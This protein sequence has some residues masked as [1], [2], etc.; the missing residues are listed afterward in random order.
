MVVEIDVLGDR[1][2]RGM[3]IRPGRLRRGF[4]L[5]VAKE[6]FDRSV[7]PAVASATHT[8][9]DPMAREEGAK[10]IAG[11]GNA[12]I[13]MMEDRRVFRD[14]RQGGPEGR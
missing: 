7:V 12:T 3:E 13:G 11:V 4:C 5:E 9:R 1:G 8:W 6:A 14:A 2:G 10:A